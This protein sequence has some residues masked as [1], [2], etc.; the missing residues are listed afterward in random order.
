MG[1]GFELGRG[2]YLWAETPKSCCFLQRSGP[3]GSQSRAPTVIPPPPP[4]LPGDPH[5]DPGGGGVQPREEPAAAQPLHGSSSLAGARGEPTDVD[6][7]AFLREAPSGSPF[8]PCYLISSPTLLPCPSF[9]TPI[10]WNHRGGQNGQ[11]QPTS[12]EMAATSCPALPVPHLTFYFLSSDSDPG[13]HCPYCGSGGPLS[14]EVRSCVLS[15]GWRKGDLGSSMASVFLEGTQTQGWR[16][17]ARPSRATG[18]PRAP[19]NNPRPRSSSSRASWGLSLPGT[20]AAVGRRT[21]SRCPGP[22]PAP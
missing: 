10:L 17:K 13:V 11:P 4:P 22:S 20:T 7:Q 1:W 8:L 9:W 3:P 2:S 16:Q 5:C 6:S 19:R 14:S 18:T 21:A 12:S 15:S